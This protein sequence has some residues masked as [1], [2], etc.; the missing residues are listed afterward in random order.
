MTAE[1]H[2]GWVITAVH[3]DDDQRRVGY[4]QGMTQANETAAS[5]A[6]VVGRTIYMSTD[7]PKDAIP[8]DH[9]VKWRSF[10]DDGDP[11]YDGVVDINWLYAP[12]EW[13]D[14]DH[15]LAYNLDRFNETDWG[16][17]CVFYNAADIRRCRP[18]L[19]EHV[20]KHSR[21]NPD[22]ERGKLAGIDAAAWICIYG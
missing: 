3:D 21:V 8:Y 18:D 17:V 12:D 19:A 10:S 15:D 4:G 7:I 22:G 16:A 1:Q 9:A 6:N 14:E 13:P 5:Y 20:A 2:I 11:A